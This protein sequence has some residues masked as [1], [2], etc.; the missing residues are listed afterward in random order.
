MRHLDDLS[1]ALEFG[2]ITDLYP[3]KLNVGYHF[4]D[5]TGNRKDFIVG[6]TYPWQNNYSISLEYR[7]RNWEIQDGHLFGSGLNINT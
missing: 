7:N 4:A 5:V 2:L 6:V 1:Y 3:G